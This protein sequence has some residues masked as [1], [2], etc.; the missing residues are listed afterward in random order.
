MLGEKQMKQEC[1]YT[2]RFWC[3]FFVCVFF[4]WAQVVCAY[5]WQT[6]V[7]FYSPSFGGTV[8]IYFCW[9]TLLLLSIHVVL[10]ALIMYSH[11]QVSGMSTKFL[12]QVYDPGGNNQHISP[13]PPPS[14]SSSGMKPKGLIKRN[15]ARTNGEVIFQ[16]RLLNWKNMI[17]IYF[18]VSQ[19]AKRIAK[20]WK[21]MKNTLKTFCP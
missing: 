21:E 1:L 19:P 10:V 8:S 13:P 4:K 2:V 18:T 17:R 9:T 6:Y 5:K 3:V 12:E 16:L 14:S 15:S 20:R 11:S 7:I